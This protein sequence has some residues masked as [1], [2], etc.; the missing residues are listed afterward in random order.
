MSQG[1]LPV[2]GQALILLLG[3]SAIAALALVVVSGMRRVP[4]PTSVFPTAHE[5][6]DTLSELAAQAERDGVAAAA[7]ASPSPLLARAI[8][9][10]GTAPTREALRRSLA[11]SLA[12]DELQTIQREGTR[13]LATT[14]VAST[15]VLL[16]LGLCT[17]I[18]L[19]NASAADVPAGMFAFASLAALIAM[20]LLSVMAARLPHAAI[21]EPAEILRRTMSV[22]AATLIATGASSLVVRESLLQLIPPSQRPVRAA[23]RAA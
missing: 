19:Q 16:T 11:A 18:F 12:K 7:A 22:E 15:L 6:A 5:H 1:L 14:A 23:T 10:Q 13:R 20:P 8:A 21:E 17:T 3:A 2:L 9:L 4:V